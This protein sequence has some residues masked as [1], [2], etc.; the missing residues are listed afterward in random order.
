[1]CLCEHNSAADPF[2]FWEGGREP[3]VVIEGDFYCE[4]DDIARVKLPANNRRGR[5]KRWR[6]EGSNSDVKTRTFSA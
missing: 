6:D 2:P 4:G 3:L 1:M 5:R